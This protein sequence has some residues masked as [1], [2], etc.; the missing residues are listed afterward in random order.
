MSEVKQT[1]ALRLKGKDAEDLQVISAVLQDAIAPVC[2]MAYLPEDKQFVMVVHRL[3]REP[4][5]EKLLERICCAVN[6]RGVT[7]AQ[8]QNID[9]AKRSRMLDLLAVMPEDKTATIVFAGDA[10]VKLH[11]EDWSVVVEDFGSPWPAQCNP[12]HDSALQAG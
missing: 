11:L 3:R 2:D 6:I 4:K 10:K 7:R 8:L 12:C 5:E 9:L 1:E